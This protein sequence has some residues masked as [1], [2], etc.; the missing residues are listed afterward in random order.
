MDPDEEYTTTINLSASPR[1]SDGEPRVAISGVPGIPVEEHRQMEREVLDRVDLRKAPSA[2]SG[3][4][5]RGKSV[6]IGEITF[7]GDGEILEIGIQREYLKPSE[8]GDGD[9]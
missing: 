1:V 8:R 2:D 3:R 5:G 7:T 9:E 6:T 4:R